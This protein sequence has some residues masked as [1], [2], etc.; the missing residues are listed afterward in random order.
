MR[1]QDQHY[2]LD[3]ETT[4][5]DKDNDEILQVACISLD[6]IAGFWRAR[7]IYKKKLHSKRQPE[8]E[9]AK[10]H[11]SKLYAEC[12]EIPETEN[13][14]LLSVG[15]RRFIHRGTYA[16]N[17]A[18]TPK[19]FMGWNASNFDLEFLFRKKVLTP[20]F[21]H[22]KDGKEVLGGDAHYRVYE[23]TGAIQL[24]SDSTG[25]SRKVLLDLALEMVPEEVRLPVESMSHDAE[26]DC[27]YQINM[28][29]GLIALAR[30][31]FKLPECT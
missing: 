31:G 22:L 19:F 6:F 25:L 26:D 12:N 29:N 16:W 23:Q 3:I 10:K 14:Y 24:L 8:S 13:L 27:K 5:V 21:Y 4:G 20:S 17:E 15:L 28:M 1:K 2:M 7:D 9:F 30:S 18:P 11:M